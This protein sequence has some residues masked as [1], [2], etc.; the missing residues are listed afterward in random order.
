MTGARGDTAES[1]EYRRRQNWIGERPGAPVTESHFVPPPPGE[2]LDRCLDDWEAWVN[3]SNGIPVVV[4]VAL[5]HYLFETIH[6]FIDGNGRIG[7]L[8]A[9]LMLIIAGEL[10]VPL[11]NLSPFFEERK[12]EY[13]DHLRRVSETGD[14]EPW[15]VFF[16]EAV[17]VQSERALVKADR[18]IRTRDEMVGQLHRAKLRGLALRITEGLISSPVVT[19]SRAAEQFGVTF[20]AANTAVR[21]L[22]ELEILTEVTGRSYGRMF[23]CPRVIEIILSR[24]LVESLA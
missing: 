7:R 23:T 24:D 16:A 3:R 13:I 14:L 17:R 8:I 9:V 22:A 10:T 21:R 2:I 11:V 5:A 19:P 20:Q 18:L 4:R 1:G 12:G 15:V 6:P